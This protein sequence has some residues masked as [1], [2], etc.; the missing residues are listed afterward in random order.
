MKSLKTYLREDYKRNF[1]AAAKIL[2][3]KDPFISIQDLLA[4]HKVIKPIRSPRPSIEEIEAAG[5]RHDGK[6]NILGRHGRILKGSTAKDNRNHNAKYKNHNLR[7]KGYGR[8]DAPRYNQ[9]EWTSRA[10]VLIFAFVHRR[11]PMDGMLIDHIDG[12]PGNNH[13]DNLREVNYDENNHWN[14]NKEQN[15]IKPIKTNS[16][17]TQPNLL[18]FLDNGTI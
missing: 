14:K 13:P 4:K 1:I 10:H 16:I 2:L 17:D 6:G 18:D 12:N 15:I 3:E 9:G 5:Y 11:W 8:K 7:V